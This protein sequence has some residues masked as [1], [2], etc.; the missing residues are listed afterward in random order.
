MLSEALYDY[1][2]YHGISM[3]I[4][5]GQ[6]KSD[7]LTLSNINS[8]LPLGIYT[9]K[10]NDFIYQCDNSLPSIFI[11]ELFSDEFVVMKKEGNSV[12]GV[13]KKNGVI[14]NPDFNGVRIIYF[15]KQ[16]AEKTVDET[17]NDLIKLSPKTTWMSS[18]LLIFAFLSP[19]YSNIFNT[20]L[21]YSDTFN[22]VL[23]I[24]IIFLV[25][26]GAEIIIR[27]HLH[28]ITSYKVCNN[29]IWLNDFYLF[30]LKNSKAKD[31]SIK[32][33]MVELSLNA[34]WHGMSMILM[35]ALIIFF[36][37]LCIIFM[38]GYYS[39][40]LLIY[41][42][43]IFALCVKL[44]LDNYT[45]TY[46]GLE[47]SVE[48]M[49]LYNVLEVNRIQAKYLYPLNLAEYLKQKILR[50]E[51]NKIKI[52]DCN[53]K[54]DELI[55]ANSFLS[56]VVMYSCCYFAVSKDF[57]GIGSIIAVMIINA[58][59]SGALTSVVSRFFVHK[60]NKEH[61]INS[62][63]AIYNDKNKFDG[64]FINKITGVSLD[65]FS[66]QISGRDLMNQVTMSFVPGD[67]VGIFG[68]SGS[69][70]TTFLKT[71]A[72]EY[73]N[74]AG[75]IRISSVS[76]KELSREFYSENISYYSPE[77]CFFKGTLRENFSLYGINDSYICADILKKIN[78]NANSIILD[79]TEA[80]DLPLS[81]GE[82]QRLKLFMT[83]HSRKK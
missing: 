61:L 28:N 2:K 45:Q 15:H 56:L 83:L 47:Y 16:V 55:K 46:M 30:L 59:L 18:F 6:I 48:K 60:V 7:A 3:Q 4:A 35:D 23:Y 31:I 40:F 43:V 64:I 72:G 67:I 5:K 73:L 27:H 36:F 41:Y 20:R 22:S 9:Y 33:R 21:I 54:W 81:N 12:K 57:I 80:N 49:A 75:D 17:Y 68:P 82:I 19:L 10:V 11:A 77:T 25:F 53:H 63:S 51:S 1:F 50:E 62:L 58:R 24:T 71:V 74:Y 38:L 34:I 44:R 52:N 14:V 26:L 37:S 13:S 29:N 79:E 65:N 70:K 78:V 42:T 39:L 76:S 66:V 69:G 8:Y 32:L